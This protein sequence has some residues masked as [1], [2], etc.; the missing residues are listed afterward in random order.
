MQ[1]EPAFISSSS[2]TRKERIPDERTQEIAPQP[3]H[4]L[5]QSLIIA[6]TERNHIKH[7]PKTATISATGQGAL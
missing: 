7:T 6:Y 5:Y 1:T 3:K 4:W 2:L